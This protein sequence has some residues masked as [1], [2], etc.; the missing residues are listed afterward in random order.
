[1]DVKKQEA[2]N[3]ALHATT[4]TPLVRLL[5]QKRQDIRMHEGKHC[6]RITR[7]KLPV[8]DLVS[9]P[10]T[11]PPSNTAAIIDVCRKKRLK[12]TLLKLH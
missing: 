4:E 8:D 2:R 1:M 7:D 12:N 6:Q 9:A 3:D 5:Q 11:T 10:I